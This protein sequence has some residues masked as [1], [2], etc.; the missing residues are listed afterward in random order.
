[1]ISR[2]WTSTPIEGHYRDN[3]RCWREATAGGSWPKATP[4]EKVECHPR[5]KDAAADDYRIGG[6]RG[7]DWAPSEM[8]FGP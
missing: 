1:V 2:I 8:H 6:G 7:V 5:F 4:G 3:T